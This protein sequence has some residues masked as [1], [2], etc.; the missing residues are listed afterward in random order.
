MTNKNKNYHNVISSNLPFKNNLHI[1][2][3]FS[4]S[5]I[6]LNPI[7]NLNASVK[8]N[9]TENSNLMQF[10]EKIKDKDNINEIPINKSK[11]QNSAKSLNNL[12]HI[13]I[14]S[15]LDNIYSNI[16]KD[17]KNQTEFISFVK[18]INQ[19]LNLNIPN[20]IKETKTNNKNYQDMLNEELKELKKE[21]NQYKRKE[22]DT[23]LKLTFLQNEK[24]KLE[25]EKIKLQE[26]LKKVNQNSSNKENQNNSVLFKYQKSL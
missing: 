13:N 26:E 20:A 16:K 9:N 22:S 12:I 3:E 25:E 5:D 1:N 4:S 18:K 8:I 15:L 24:N 14:K 19:E 17:K 23:K 21:L 11:T 7:L 2:S 10:L 6:L